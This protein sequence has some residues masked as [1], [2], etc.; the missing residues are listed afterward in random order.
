MHV[1]AAS[2]SQA[3]YY[4]MT[5]AAV[6]SMIWRMKMA[7]V[8]FIKS[9]A[10]IGASFTFLSFNKWFHMG[11]TNLG[12]LVD[13]GCETHIYSSIIYLLHCHY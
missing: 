7:G 12:D 5:V 1:P 13:L 8:F 3:I 6:V 11:T 10:P 2:V 4:T 9:M